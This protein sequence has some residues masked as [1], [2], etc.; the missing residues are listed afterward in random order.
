MAKKEA[1]LSQPLASAALRFKTWR[2]CRTTHRIPEELWAVAAEL[3][4][5]FGVSRT[6][7]AVG[8]G[9]RGL[10]GRVD[11]LNATKPGVE[12]RQPAFV[13]IVAPPSSS[14]G[15][16][17]VEFESRGQAKMRIHVKGSHALD[18]VELSRVFIEQ[19]S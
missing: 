3:G 16:C 13:E 9:Y 12:A 19:C 1:G 10:K 14:T 6:A 17:S 2:S 5:R 8:V 18:L 15:E 4:A 7:Q 11:A